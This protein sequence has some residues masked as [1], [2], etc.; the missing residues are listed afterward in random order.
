MGRIT[1]KIGTI[2]MMVKTL[3]LLEVIPMF[4]EMLL[5]PEV[6]VSRYSKLTKIQEQ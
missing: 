5:L 6:M 4:K 2:S 3:L 1:V